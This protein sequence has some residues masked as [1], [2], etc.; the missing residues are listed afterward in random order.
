LRRLR[1]ALALAIEQVGLHHDDA[2]GG[3]FRKAQTAPAV[4]ARL[5]SAPPWSMPPVVQRC[6]AQGRTAR[7]SS[8]AAARSSMPSVAGK[9]TE[10]KSDA[11]C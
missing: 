9:G 5:M 1:D 2:P 10:A 4:S 11:A 3:R 6:A 8:F 7:T